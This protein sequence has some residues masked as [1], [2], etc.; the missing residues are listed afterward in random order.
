MRTRKRLLISLTMLLSGCKSFPDVRAAFITT[1]DDEV[2]PVCLIAPKSGEPA[3]KKPIQ[4][5]LDMICYS[6]DDHQKIIEWGRRRI[7]VER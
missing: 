2:T 6:P 1:D 4:N 3:E 5:C 7:N